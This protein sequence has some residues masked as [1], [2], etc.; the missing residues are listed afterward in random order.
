MNAA[1]VCAV[2]SERMEI[3]FSECA[4]ID[5]LNAK[6][7][8]AL[9]RGEEL[10]LVQTQHVVECD[11]RRDRRFANAD[12]ADLVRLH[13]DDFDRAARERS[14]QGGCGHPAGSSSADDD[15]L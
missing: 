8:R 5:K 3:A 10:I 12:R 14:R 1:E 7:E 2:R 4:P 9:G 13:E 11:E 6:L 15:N